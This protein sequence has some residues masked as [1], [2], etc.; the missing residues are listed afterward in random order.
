MCFA[1]FGAL[2]PPGGASP[3]IEVM[4]V[5]APW[6]IVL[7]LSLSVIL[8]GCGGVDVSAQTVAVSPEGPAAGSPLMDELRVPAG[9][10]LLGAAFPRR[11]GSAALLLV[12]GDPV[13]AFADLVRQARQAG[14][15]LQ[16]DHAGGHA[17]LLSTVK[18][19]WW[20]HPTQ[21]LG[22]QPAP[23]GTT[24]LVCAASG[25]TG[26]RSARQRFLQLRL[27]VSTGD[28]P[29][30]A[31]I[32]VG[33]SL[34]DGSAVAMPAP[35]SLE[36][37]QPGSPV[38]P[39]PLPAVPGVGAELGAP[40]TARLHPDLYHVA[41]G[42]RLI[43]PAFAWGIVCGSNFGFAVV[44]KITGKPDTV[45]SDYAA[46]FAKDNL[47]DQKRV[48]L[49]GAGGNATAVDA[50]STD[51][52]GGDASATAVTSGIRTYLLIDRCGD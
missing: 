22:Q 34:T 49:A 32:A 21:S 48:Q 5:R 46:Q 41:A 52:T 1:S 2:D 13:A 37:P 4:V 12:T 10:R 40:F 39:L 51:G 45:M 11:A 16:A 33:L 26:P 20:D 14:F 9:T 31:H 17:C 44:L 42:S 6:V 43:A 15:G 50:T 24:G 8:G 28:H 3:Y 30:L 18:Y 38:E 47:T 23:T 27:A 25:S 29:Y 19:D 7:V 36:L 35:G